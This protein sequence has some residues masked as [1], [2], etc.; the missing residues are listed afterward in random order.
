MKH[1]IKG[2]LAVSVLAGLMGIGWWRYNAFLTQGMRPSEG[3]QR[4]NRMEKEGVPE[5]NIETIDG[6]KFHLRDF[7]DRLVIVSFWASWCEP[8]VQEFPSMIKLVDFFKGRIVLVAVS[9]DRTL[10]DIH[11]FFKPYGK[12]LPKDV[13]V[14]WDKDQKIATSY[15]TEALPESYIL[16]PGLKM[17]RKV[18]G[19]EDWFS[20]GAIQLF[21]EILSSGQSSSGA[22]SK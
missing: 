12:D 3:T 15:G 1:F 11:S 16:G 21:H 9:A 18:S 10:E 20:P 6:R 2:L 7:T 4:L 5:F 17:V 22:V 14:M 19:S 8:C 13:I